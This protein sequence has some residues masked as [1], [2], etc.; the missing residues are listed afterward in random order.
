MTITIIILSYVISVF[1]ARWFNKKS[2]ELDG[3]ASIPLIWFIP[4]LGVIAFFVIYILVIFKID[5]K[6]NW[7]TGKNWK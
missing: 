3:G 1:V 7:F 2:Y 4:V 5:S 6:H